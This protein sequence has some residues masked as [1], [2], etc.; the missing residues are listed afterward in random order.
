MKSCMSCLQ[1]RSKKQEARS[2]K[3]EARSKKQEARGK[4]HEARSKRQAEF[5]VPDAAGHRDATLP[6]SA[7]PFCAGSRDFP[8]SERNHSRA[9]LG[10]F[11]HVFMDGP[12]RLSAFLKYHPSL[13]VWGMDG[14]AASEKALEAPVTN[15]QITQIQ[16]LPHREQQFTLTQDEIQRLQA[17]WVPQPFEHVVAS[18]RKRIITAKTANRLM[19]R[20]YMRC[21]CS[22]RSQC[23]PPICSAFERRTK[24]RDAKPEN[25]QRTGRR[26]E[27]LLEIL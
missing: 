7:D 6:R 9:R 22:Q 13:A 11:K 3:Q 15:A 18:M 12:M 21:T 5:P 10:T 26:H 19:L 8:H 17:L 14:I 16:Q 23:S 24:Q 4:R 1:R 27:R 20:R 25:R 2:K